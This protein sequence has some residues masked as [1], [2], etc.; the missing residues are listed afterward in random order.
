M[1]VSNKS[2]KNLIIILGLVF[3]CLLLLCIRLGWLQIVKSDELSAKATQQQTRDTPIEAERGVIYDTNGHELAVSVTCY[4]IWARPS[5]IKA[6]DTKAER[7]ARVEDVTEILSEA[8]KM[9]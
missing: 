2:K 3:I 8:L 5:D 1:A 6:A 9:D 4:T 7:K